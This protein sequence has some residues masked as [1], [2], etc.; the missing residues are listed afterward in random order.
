MQ[1]GEKISQKIFQSEA[2]I[3]SRKPPHLT[4]SLIHIAAYTFHDYSETSVGGWKLPP[5][6][7]CHRLFFKGEFSQKTMDQ[8]VWQTLVAL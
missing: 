4:W 7:L 8:A 6:Q 1:I 3:L 5:F 2:K